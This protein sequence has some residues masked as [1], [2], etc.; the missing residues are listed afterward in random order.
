MAP[1][2]P[3]LKELGVNLVAQAGTPCLHRSMAP[4][5]VL[6]LSELVQEVMKDRTCSRNLPPAGA[7][8]QQRGTDRK[9]CSRPIARNGR[10]WCSVRDLSL[11]H[12]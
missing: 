6:R 2:I 4:A 10:R 11:E 3:T 7:C 1:T 12:P 9:P 8:G 5:T